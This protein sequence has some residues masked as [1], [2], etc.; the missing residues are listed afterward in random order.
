MKKLLPLL[1]LFAIAP[2]FAQSN[3][4]FAP[5]TTTPTQA[6][7]NPHIVR[8]DFNIEDS[9][10]KGGLVFWLHR[11]HRAE[12]LKLFLDYEIQTT[13]KVSVIP[14]HGVFTLDD[15]ARWPTAGACTNNGKRITCEL[16]AGPGGIFLD[17]DGSG[18]GTIFR[19]AGHSVEAAGRTGKISRIKEPVKEK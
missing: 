3:D 17:M 19:S 9:D 2:A 11:T 5:Q 16:S 15:G 18:N 4:P 13:K 6:P 14:A 1:A 8:I 10:E 7:V 12:T